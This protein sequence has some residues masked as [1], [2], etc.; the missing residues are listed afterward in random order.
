MHIGI[1]KK[2]SGGPDVT[3]WRFSSTLL[4]S[5]VQQLFCPLF[6]IL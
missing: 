2:E 6:L 3:S 4:E 5:G 1:K